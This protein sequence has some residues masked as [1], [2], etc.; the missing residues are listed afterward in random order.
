VVLARSVS[1]NMHC[2]SYPHE[3]ATR[4]RHAAAATGSGHPGAHAGETGCDALVVVDADPVIDLVPGHDGIGQACPG[5]RCVVGWPAV[6]AQHAVADLG[7]G[8]D[9]PCEVADRVAG[10]ELF[11]VDHGGEVACGVD[12]DVLGAEVRMRERRRELP[13]AL[14]EARVE[15]RVGAGALVRFEARHDGGAEA[16]A[17]GALAIAQGVG[18]DWS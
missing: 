6:A 13:V 3:P 11:P 5:A 4:Y 10:V 15:Q 1:P 18:T 12:E 16:I 8:M 17:R 14:V 2:W 9:P 7:S